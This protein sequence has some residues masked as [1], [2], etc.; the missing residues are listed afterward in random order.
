MKFSMFLPMRSEEGQHF[1]SPAALKAIA[2]AAERAGYDA[3][4]LTDHPAPTAEWRRAG[5]HDGLDPFAAFAFIAGVTTRIRLHTHIVVLPY[6]NPLLTAQSAA[7]VDV[8]SEGR[9]ILG[10][11]SGYL[12]G[13]YAALG[14]DFESR[15][16]LMDEALEVMKLAW[17]GESVVYEGRNFQAVGNEPRPLPVQKPHPP[18]WGG[19]NGGRAIRR[20]AELCDGWAP[21][22]APPELAK[23]AR[24]EE[25]VTLEDLQAKI[26]DVRSHLDRLG[27]TGPFD[28]CAAPPQQLQRCSSSEAQRFVDIAGA[29]AEMGVTWM[30]NSL[31]AQDLPGLLDS[32]QWFG[33]EV[34]P[35]A[36][37]VHAP[38]IASEAES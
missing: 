14:V 21:F 17:S 4:N 19:G 6:R 27:R 9:L 7:T 35:K 8:L 12:K 37:T 3:C 23:R 33:D 34:L 26:M 11:A 30:V 32:I 5:G 28:I 22:F 29:M 24:T 2:Q 16:A 20:A 36:R 18:I 15:G 31:P 1:Q 38:P 13:E 10:V 25:L